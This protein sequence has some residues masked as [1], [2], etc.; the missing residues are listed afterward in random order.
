L[1]PIIAGDRRQGADVKTRTGFAFTDIGHILTDDRELLA[2]YL[3]A[4]YG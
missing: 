2:R 4:Y 1:P 3:T